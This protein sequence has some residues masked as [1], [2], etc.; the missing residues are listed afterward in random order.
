MLGSGAEVIWPPRSAF[1]L[2]R[3]GR[4]DLGTSRSQGHSLSARSCSGGHRL[5][6]G[7]VGWQLQ[8]LF[9]EEVVTIKRHLLP[10]TS[11]LQL[12]FFHLLFHLVEHLK[13]LIFV[14]LSGVSVDERLLWRDRGSA[15]HERLIVGWFGGRASQWWLW[16]YLWRLRCQ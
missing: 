9:T 1:G 10:L 6:S 11:C 13:E 14:L 3:R 15:L 16:P 8:L 4:G 5:E 7:D 2:V 12:L